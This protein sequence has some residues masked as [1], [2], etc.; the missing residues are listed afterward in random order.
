M[1]NGKAAT[2]CWSETKPL[3]ID[4]LTEAAM[5]LPEPFAVIDDHDRIVFANLAF[6]AAYCV[7]EGARMTDIETHRVSAE[8]EF[9]MSGLSFGRRL[10]TREIKAGE[11]L[12]ERVDALTGLPNR[13]VLREAL[14]RML[15][16][17]QACNESALLLLDLDRFKFVNDT[18]GHPIGDKLLCRVVDR[19]RKVLRDGDLLV[20]L[21]GDEFAILHASQKQPESARAIAQR[22]V[23]LVGRSYL[24]DDHLVT[25]G[26]SI[27][28]ATTL[29]GGSDAD[30]LIKSAD[31]AL[32]GAKEAGRGQFRFFEQEMDD[33]AQARRTLEQDMRRALALRQFSLHYQ[34]QAD[35]ADKTILGFEALLR[36]KHPTLGMI[37]PAAFI[38]VAEETGLIVQIGEWVLRAACH[39]AARWPEDIT[40]AVNLSPVQIAHHGL[41]DVVTS[42]LAN[43]GISPGRLELEITETVL[44]QDTN[45]TLD[46]LHRLRALGVRIA[47]DDFGT[48]YSSLSYLRAFPFDKVKIDQSFI[49]EMSTDKEAAA[50]VRAVIGLGISLGISMTAEGVETEEQLQGLRNEGCTELQGFLISRP[51]PSADVAEFLS[52]N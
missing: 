5:R 10:V 48:G 17:P 39:E 44:L 24:I 13:L 4:A 27:G 45:S 22:I 25:I 50:I 46:T 28:I 3:P 11:D 16:D 8:T 18:L 19:I 6:R 1:I 20:R 41:I 15:A 33:R 49:R 23:D 9:R 51:I 2:L 36:W 21:G 42:A 47:M 38:P 34:P 14:E 29:F 52:R 12:R 30:R 26:T 31:L 40:I 35:I 37:S 32:Y 43:A 7:N